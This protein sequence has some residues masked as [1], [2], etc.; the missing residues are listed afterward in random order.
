MRSLSAL[1]ILCIVS[2]AM[3]ISGCADAHYASSSGEFKSDV[4]LEQ[5]DKSPA[6][7]DFI[8][9]AGSETNSTGTNIVAAAAKNRKMIYRAQVEVVTRDFA[10]SSTTIRELVDASGGF[11]TNSHSG[12]TYG[13]QRE[14]TWTIRIPVEQFDAFL[15]NLGKVGTRVSENIESDDV[16]EEYVD[17][18]ARIKST[19]AVESRLLKLLDEKTGKLSD[20][21]QA[22]QKLAEVRMK[23]EQMQ[24]RMRFLQDRIALTTITLTL[25]EQ[26]DY[27]P[28]EDLPYGE[29]VSNAWSDSLGALFTAA[30]NVSIGLVAAAPWL[31]V[32]LVLLIFFVLVLMVFIKIVRWIFKGKEPAPV[33]AQPVD[34]E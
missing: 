4:A 18:E 23:I 7:P 30:S 22:E 17:L 16:T 21:I 29:K 26:R 24:G 2:L 28:P 20:I 15:A 5:A 10:K 13:D 14:G 31:V 6:S 9:L 34:K 32:L 25:T 11:V 33:A 8:A 1:S 19:Q 12:R 3:A 27:I